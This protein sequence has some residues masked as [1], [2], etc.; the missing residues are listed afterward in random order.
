MFLQ[1]KP[2]NAVSFGPLRRDLRSSGDYTAPRAISAMHSS[3]SL[4]VID[5]LNYSMP[6]DKLVKVLEMVP[7]GKELDDVNFY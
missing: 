6:H 5:G 2:Q 3:L 7:T 4:G 1:P